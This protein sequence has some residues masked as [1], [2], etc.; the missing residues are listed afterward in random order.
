[1]VE[2]IREISDVFFAMSLIRMGRSQVLGLRKDIARKPAMYQALFQSWEGNPLA[3]QKPE[4]SRWTDEAAAQMGGGSWSAD[5]AL[6]F[7]RIFR[8][9]LNNRSFASTPNEG[10]TLHNCLVQFQDQEAAQGAPYLWAMR[11][12]PDVEHYARLPRYERWPHWMAQQGIRQMF[13]NGWHEVPLL[14]KSTLQTGACNKAG[15]WALMT[16]PAA[17]A[18]FAPWPLAAEVGKRCFLASLTKRYDR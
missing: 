2:P 4:G 3:P 14:Q 11:V 9:L 16:R 10:A 17:D 6:D 5:Q 7:V 18:Y 15:I 12:R 13:T 1:M 8:P